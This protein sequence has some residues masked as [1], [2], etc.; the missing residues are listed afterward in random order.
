MKLRLGFLLS[1]SLA[2]AFASVSIFAEAG[3]GEKSAPLQVTSKQLAAEYVKNK[4]AAEKK[5]GDRYNPKE[6]IVEGIVVRFD[7]NNFG[8]IARLEGTGKVTVSCLLRTEDEA[9]V[10]QGEKVVIRGKCR[11]LYDDG[12]AQLVDINGGVVVKAKQ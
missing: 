3:D 7:K 6:L 4:K 8:K 5:Y 9:S 1:V 12:D 2:V 11:G 10:K